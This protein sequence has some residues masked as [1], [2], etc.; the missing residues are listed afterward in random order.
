M[1]ELYMEDLLREINLLNHYK[2][3][4]AKRK[5]ADAVLIQS[6]A[7]QQDALLNHI[8]SAVTDVLSL[9]NPN[10]LKF[11]CDYSDDKLTFNL[12]PIREGTEHIVSLLKESVRQYI[13]YEVR[14]LWLMLVAPDMA[15][16]ALRQELTAKIQKTI[17]MVGKGQRIRRRPTDLAGI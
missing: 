2:G 17:R 11:T 14:R 12:Q 5:D 13:I 1:F 16:Y 8:R 15:E 9:A 7:E 6:A 3:E 4:A 10:V